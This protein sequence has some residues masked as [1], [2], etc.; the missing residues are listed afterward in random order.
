[1]SIIIHPEYKRLK[2]KLSN[3]ILE[4]ETLKFQICPELERRYLINFGILEFELYK[5]DVELAKLKRKL[6]LIQIQINHELEIDI[7][8]INERL[9]EEFDEYEENIKKQMEK[10][11]NVLDG[12]PEK[13]LSKEDEK[14]LK[15]ISKQCVLK[16]HPDLN[17]NQT[18]YEKNLF[19]EINNAFKNGDLERL[20]ALYYLIPN[21]EFDY[22]S[23]MDRLK[24][25]IE[26]IESEISEIKAKYPY[27]KKELLSSDENIQAYKSELEYLIKQYAEEIRNYEN[28]IWGLI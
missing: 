13:Y 7:D 6:Q 8:E 17:P 16:L 21:G 20:E 15:L 28:R 9:D 18:E 14:R 3:L 25:L 23:D 10:L 27:N 19:L 26:N 1:M 22:V 2:N 24:E 5:K 11:Q 12:F 4:C